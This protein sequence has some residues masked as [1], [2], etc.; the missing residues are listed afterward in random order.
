[1]VID[2]SSSP[3]NLPKKPLF[4]NRLVEVDRVAELQVRA[5]ADGEPLLV[6]LTGPQGIGKTVLAVS[7][8][9][10]FAPDFPD[11]VLFC[12]ARG[13]DTRN[14]C[15]ADE[16][17]RQLLVQLG[18]PWAEVPASPHDRLQT[19]RSAMAGKR[20]LFIFDDVE[21]ASQ[22]E[23]LLGDVSRAAVIVTS[24]SRLKSL[25]IGQQ[26]VSIRLP[27]FDQAAA[28]ELVGAIAG[29][30]VRDVPESVLAKVCSICEGLPLALAVT[31]GKLSDG[32]ELLEDVVEQ[33]TRNAMDALDLDGNFVVKVLFDE[34]YRE[35]TAE[36]QRAY[37]LLTLVPGPHFGPAVAAAALDAPEPS[38]KRLLGHFVRSN[39]LQEAGKGRYRYHFLVREHAAGRLREDATDEELATQA[40]ADLWYVRR[41][42]ALDKAFAGRPEPHGAEEF[43]AVVDAAFSG[44]DKAVSAAAE[45]DTEWPNLLAAAQRR[46]DRG[47]LVHTLVAATALCSYAY[48]AGR[49][50]EVI[51]LYLRL[52]DLVA[53]EPER[54]QVYRDLAQLHERL[55][56]YEEVERFASEAEAIHPPGRESAIT[57]RA[58]SYES[59]GLLEQADEAFREAGGA[60]S[61]MAEPGQ[62]DRATA[63][64]MMHRGRIAVKRGLF[65]DASPLLEDAAR[66]FAGSPVDGANTARCEAL[67]GDIARQRGDLD[68]AERR[69]LTA[70]EIFVAHHAWTDATSTY[71]KLALLAGEVGRPEDAA[72]HQERARKIEEGRGSSR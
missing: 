65:D 44:P 14:A 27:G 32:D 7:L 11:G 23:P 55:G 6:L 67:L 2:R 46:A 66:S 63:L 10:R 48:Q 68:D 36:E 56:E 5:L 42:V 33:L 31:A 19:L 26:F 18:M 72:V 47:D 59:R 61:A 1:M 50:V 39:V 40:H 62:R 38:T 51:D 45:F 41:A 30:A 16:L 25:E 24:R 13:S 22:I 12:E 57:W 34:V 58:L 70:V 52:L 69:W 43:R 15:S 49:C 35:L 53:T 17:A 71:R 8:G 28:L 60:V 21:V 20:L 29:K 54:W 64:L 9:Y 3:M 4:V 37:R